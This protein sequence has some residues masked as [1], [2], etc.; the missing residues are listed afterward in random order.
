L[1]IEFLL[2]YFEEE[3]GVARKN[4]RV[5]VEGQESKED[6]DSDAIHNYKSSALI[7][8]SKECSIDLPISKIVR[9]AQDSFQIDSK[10][11][12]S[13]FD[14]KSNVM[15]DVVLNLVKK[16]C[17]ATPT[18]I[19]ENF[20]IKRTAVSDAVKRARNKIDSNHELKNQCER[21]SRA[22]RADDVRAIMNFDCWLPATGHP[23]PF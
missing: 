10:S 13:Q 9:V 14:R 21:L 16:N 1:S 5:F 4:F 3:I 22:F 7:S 2:G 17:K 19:G 12:Q 15:R 6:E 8:R 18:Q 20:G 23:A 11:L